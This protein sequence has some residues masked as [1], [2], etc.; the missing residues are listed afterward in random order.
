MCSATNEIIEV[1]GPEDL[2]WRETCQACFAALSKPPRISCA[3][4]GLCRLALVLLR[5]F[6]YRLWA[7]GRLLLF[8]ST[9]DVR[10]PRRGTLR[11]RDYLAA[12]RA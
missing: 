9:H 3:P 6:S 1:G 7:M 12:P 10:T 2:T 11:L 5:P 8:M 4:V